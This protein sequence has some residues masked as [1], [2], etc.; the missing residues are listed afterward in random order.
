M[1]SI[2]EQSEGAAAAI[3][4]VFVSLLRPRFWRRVM[5]AALT[6]APDSATPRLTAAAAATVWAPCAIA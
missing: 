4:A 5:A 6:G 1:A 2:P 3:A